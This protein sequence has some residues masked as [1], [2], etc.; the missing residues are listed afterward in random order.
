MAWA[1]KGMR[2]EDH[3]LPWQRRMTKNNAY[4]VYKQIR[5][6]VLTT[7]HLSDKGTVSTNSATTCANSR[8]TDL[9]SVTEPATPTASP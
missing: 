6:G 9:S 8:V 1:E 2:K 3:A 4:G 7:F 5:Q